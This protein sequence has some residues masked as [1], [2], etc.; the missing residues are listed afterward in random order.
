MGVTDTIVVGQL[1]SAEL[2]YLALGW[3][4]TGVLIVTG[5]GALMGVQVLA[6]RVIGEGRPQ[7]A[8]AVWRRGVVLAM[9]AGT[10][11]SLALFA[12]A[13]WLFFAIGIAPDLSR[14]SAA[15]SRILAIGLPLH[16]IY[17][18]SSFFLEA[19]RRPLVGTL[20]I[21]IANVLNVVVNVL[22]VPQLG[23][24]GSAWATVAARAFMAA[25][26]VAYILWGPFGRQFAVRD[27]SIEAPGYRM[28]YGVGLAAGISQAAEAGAFS[29]MTMIAGRIGENAVAAYQ[30]LLNVL[31]VVFMVAL[32]LAAATSVAVAHAWGGR[33]V[34][35]ARH[36]AWTGLWLNTLA[37]AASA[38]VLLA[39]PFA[40]ARGFTADAALAALIASLLPIA[41][42]ILAPDG[43]Q[44]VIA[45]ALR[46]RGDNWFPTASHIVAYVVVMPPAGY[47]LGERLG[48]GVAGLMEAILAASVLSVAVLLLRQSSLTRTDR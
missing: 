7:A 38:V 32:G 19:I 25:T 24:E 26:V 31:A 46:A 15:V 21:W 45:S 34:R 27:T 1:A 42:L 11:A 29:A 47:L 13:E 2:P 40:I 5:M 6:A 30:I 9:A 35:A 12:V 28:L 8:G 33:D 36:A 44:V 3:A 37:M 10:I 23:A 43:G 22:L 18:A 20:I 17:T 14:E 39:A 4:P 16:F 48:R 41:A